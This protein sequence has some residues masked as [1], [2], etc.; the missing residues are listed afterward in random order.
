MFN[1]P[2]LLNIPLLFLDE[3]LQM[4]AQQHQIL[5]EVVNVMKFGF[6]LAACQE[7]ENSSNKFIAADCCRNVLQISA[8]NSHILVDAYLLEFSLELNEDLTPIRH[9]PLYQIK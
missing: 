7:P 8:V 4:R 9:N 5:H 1:N 2:S 6:T 3:F